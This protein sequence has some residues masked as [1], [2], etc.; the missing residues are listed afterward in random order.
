MRLD[1]QGGE[2]DADPAVTKQGEIWP[3]YDP[4]TGQRRW[5]IGWDADYQNTGPATATAVH[6][7]D[8]FAAP[9]TLLA[10]N[11]IPLVP[12]TSSGNTLDYNVGNLPVGGA[13]ASFMVNTTAP[14]NTAPGTVL[15]NTIVINSSND[16]N[17][18]NNTAVA[19]VTVPL[20]PPLHLCVRWPAPPVR[21]RSRSR[22]GC[23]PARRS[24][25]TSTTC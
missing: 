24:I 1:G 22:A 4:A 15:T 9:Q 14:F 20:L 25:S 7:V 8:T 3:D 10:E 18:L 5:V 6:V 12:H 19:T 16:G 2:D 13:P 11:S 17:T 23:N 21:A